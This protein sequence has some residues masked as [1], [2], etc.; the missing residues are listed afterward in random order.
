[1]KSFSEGI[2]HSILKRRMDYAMK[3][4]HN[5]LEPVLVTV[6]HTM[7]EGRGPCDP[8]DEHSNA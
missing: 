2:K 6:F 3:V 5:T 1:M 7:G 8:W 4:Y